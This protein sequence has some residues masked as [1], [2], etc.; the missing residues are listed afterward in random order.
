MYKIAFLSATLLASPALAD[1]F[2]G[3]YAT[4][5]VGY[6]YGSNDGI[7]TDVIPGGAEFEANANLTDFYW[8]SS[9]GYNWAINDSYIAGVEATL[10][11]MTVSDTANQKNRNTSQYQSAWAIRSDVEYTYSLRAKIGKKLL[12]DKAL[13]YTSGGPVIAKVHYGLLNLNGNQDE[14]ASVTHK[15]IVGAI[16]AKYSFTDNFSF[17]SEASWSEFARETIDANVWRKVEHQDLSLGQVKVGV[18]Y[19]F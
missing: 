15:G 10:D 13:I 16:G 12:D 19:S 9:L 4:G 8:A 3:L 14:E 18:S 7:E 11:W 1:N 5:A 6:V 2:T 17:F